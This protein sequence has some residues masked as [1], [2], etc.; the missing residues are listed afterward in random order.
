MKERPTVKIDLERCNGCGLC[1]KDCPV[2]AITLQDKKAVIG[3]TCVECHTCFR[4]CPRKA[5]ADE[6]V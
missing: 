3:Q 4:V 5:V 6:L 1:V 2:A